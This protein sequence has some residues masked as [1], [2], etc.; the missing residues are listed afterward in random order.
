MKIRGLYIQKRSPFYWLRYYDKLEPDPKK[1]SKSIC[2]KIEISSA[3]LRRIEEAALQNTRPVLKGTPEV[4]AFADAFRK[5]LHEI[6]VQN[7]LKMKLQYQLLL[8]DAYKEFVTERSIPG[9]KD[10]LRERSIINYGIAIEHLIAACGDREV[11]TYSQEDFHKLLHYFQDYKFKGIKEKDGTVSVKLLSQTTR[12]IYVRTLK[13][14]WAHFL[15]KG[16]AREQIFENLRVEDADPEPIP[17]DDMW[18]IL[19]QLKNNSNYPN[20]YAIIRFLFLTGCRVS[21]AMVQLK[22]NI[23]FNEKVIKIQNVKSGRRKGRE[24]YLFPLYGELEFLLREEMGVN[25]GD[26][27]RL[28]GHFKINELDYTSPLGFWDRLMNTLAKHGHIKKKYTL[29]QI[30][31][32]AASYF[33]NNLRFDI[34]RVKKL[35]DHSDVK[36]TERNYIRYDVE[37]VRQVLDE[38]MKMSKLLRN[39]L[40]DGITEV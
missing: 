4:R 2:T 23:D 16:L 24:I 5:G 12:S 33:I 1:K 36:V 38:E 7:R 27:G 3:D 25:P 35:L 28:F 6:W 17:L 19:S 9:K 22:E 15:K 40:E 21:S 20:A 37:L 13:S 11:H 30:R 34:Y 31:S 26:T 10:Q 18:R 14:L 8:S 39:S 29:K 32:T